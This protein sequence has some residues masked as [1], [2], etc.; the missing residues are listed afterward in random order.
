MS[1]VLEKCSSHIKKLDFLQETI[2]IKFTMNL[3]MPIGVSGVAGAGKDLFFELISRRLPVRR[4]ALADALKVDVQRWCIDRY[5]IDPTNCS[6][7]D[8]EK[9]REFLVFHGT[10]MRKRSEGRFWIDKLDS[11]IKS[12]LLNAQSN[13]IP[14]VTDIRYSEYKKD[15]VDWVKNELNGVVVHIS[16]YEIKDTVSKRN[17]PKKEMGRVYREPVNFEEARQDPLLKS[18]ADFSVE[19]EKIKCDNPSENEYLNKKAEKFVE[20]YNEETKNRQ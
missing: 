2:Y 4:F 15:E 9:V 12:F 13:D 5:G 20:W 1:Y 14:I 3:R 16:Q 6:R 8:K 11:K 10:F 18:N 17:W 7:E 19:W